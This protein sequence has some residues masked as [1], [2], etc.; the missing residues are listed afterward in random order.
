M[1]YAKTH[2]L[3]ISRRVGES[4]LI[5]DEDSP[6]GEVEVAQI[7]GNKVRLA[8]RFPG[9]VKIMRAEIEDSWTDESK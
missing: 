3:V 1:D 9:E 6:M 8:F 4:V 7:A 2:T 5:G